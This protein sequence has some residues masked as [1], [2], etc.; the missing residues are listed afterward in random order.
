[1]MM[2]CAVAYA[3]LFFGLGAR[4]SEIAIVA[5]VIAIIFVRL[6]IWTIKGTAKDMF[7]S[8]LCS[9]VFA[10]FLLLAGVSMT[11]AGEFISG[12]GV[13]LLGTALAVAGLLAMVGRTAYKKWQ[14]AKNDHG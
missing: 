14:A 12:P 10:G 13:L 5:I 7:G 1:M 6:G 3:M 9:F 8:S 4:L 11:A 2:I